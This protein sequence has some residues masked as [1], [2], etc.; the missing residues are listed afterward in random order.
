MYAGI[1]QLAY[2]SNGCPTI[3]VTHCTLFKNN[4]KSKARK[5]AT[6]EI[7]KDSKTRYFRSVVSELP[8][9][10]WMVIDLVRI[11]AKAIHRLISLTKAIPMIRM[12]IKNNIFVRSLLPMGA[13]SARTGWPK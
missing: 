4:R 3:F 10:F 8:S 7:P 12:A 13:A 5:K 2:R 11:G 1:F 6:T 9:T